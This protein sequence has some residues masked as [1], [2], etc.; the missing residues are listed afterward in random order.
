M[1]RDHDLLEEENP[2]MPT[3]TTSRRAVFRG[4]GLTSIAAGLA[5]RPALAAP[6]AAAPDTDAELIRLCGEVVAI[7]DRINALYRVRHTVEDERRTEPELSAL[8]ATQQERIDLIEAAGGLP[9]TLAGARAIA[10]ASVAIA[11]LDRGGETEFEGG[12]AEWLALTVVKFLA[13]GDAA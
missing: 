12:D 1:K 2:P 3:F 5:A 11:P 10:Q 4:L 8:Y 13:A 7:Q 6:A 9:A